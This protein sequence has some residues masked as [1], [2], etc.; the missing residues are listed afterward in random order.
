MPEDGLSLKMFY[1]FEV[2][3]FNNAK[4]AVRG[5]GAEAS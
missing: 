3:L 1:I 4:G 2:I 5:T